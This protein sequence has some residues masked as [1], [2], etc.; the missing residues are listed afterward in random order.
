MKSMRTKFLIASA[1]SGMMSVAQFAYA[2]DST[3]AC[4]I[5]VSDAGLMGKITSL[6]GRVLASSPIGFTPAKKGQV[7]TQQSRVLSGPDSRV[8]ANFGP[9]CSVELA[10]NSRMSILE[11]NGSFCVQTSVTIASSDTSIHVSS[12]TTETTEVPAVELTTTNAAGAGAAPF[13]AL[14]AVAVAVGLGG[15]SSSP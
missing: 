14:G 12:Q 11:S 2:D 6:E 8:T 4:Q 7:L 13:I 9:S 1:F 5:G 3:C 15:S 10:S